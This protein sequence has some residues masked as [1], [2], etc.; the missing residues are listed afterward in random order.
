MRCEGLSG[1]W[2]ARRH[3]REEAA[4]LPGV[5]GRSFRCYLE[6]DEGKALAGLLDRRLGAASAGRARVDAVSHTEALDR[7]RD[8]GWLVERCY[9]PR[10]HDQTDSRRVPPAWNAASAGVGELAV[11]ARLRTGCR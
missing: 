5:G 6:R 10:G 4:L 3:P 1:G 7:E 9:G 2:P 11:P 8:D